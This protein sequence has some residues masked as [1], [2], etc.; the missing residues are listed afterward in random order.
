MHENMLNSVRE[1]TEFAYSDAIERGI[2]NPVVFVLDV[3]DD[4]AAWVA[5]LLTD[6]TKIDDAVKEAETRQ[7]IP[8]L[9]F[10][11]SYD[12]AKKI[13]GQLN[14]ETEA[15]IDA[16]VVPDTQFL[17]IAIADGSFSGGLQHRP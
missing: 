16:I 5:E 1:K 6:R 10:A 7:T 9:T 11:V 12:Q 15:Q 13:C 4:D 3:R 14:P 2:E 8:T 17:A